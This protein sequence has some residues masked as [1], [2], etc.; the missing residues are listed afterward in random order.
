MGDDIQGHSLCFEIVAFFMGKKPLVVN[1]NKQ[2][3][4]DMVQG[5][6]PDQVDITLEK[7]HAST[8]CKKKG[9]RPNGDYL[10]KDSKN[11]CCTYPKCPYGVK[12]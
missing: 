6:C 2:G 7:R 12:L 5:N 10:G 9:A 1:S 8:G 4:E 11:I 3:G